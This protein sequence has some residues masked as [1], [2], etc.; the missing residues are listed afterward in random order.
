MAIVVLYSKLMAIVVLHVYSKLM[1]IVI[2]YSNQYR[3][4]DAD[5]KPL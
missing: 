4:T 1:A 3:R 5:M 2:L